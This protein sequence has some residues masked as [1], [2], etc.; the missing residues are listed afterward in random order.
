MVIQLS[1]GHVL[2]WRGYLGHLRVYTVFRAYM[3][4]PLLYGSFAW[5]NGFS[6]WLYVIAW[7]YNSGPLISFFC[8]VIHFFRV[9]ISFCA[10]IQLSRGY[11]V[12]CHGY[13]VHL[14]VYM[15]FR[16]YMTFPWLYGS[17][18]G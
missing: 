11:M 6:S 17:L 9:V 4:F 12:L 2:L 8:M 7:L 1:R 16:G 10:V 15:V 13:L 5:L 18:R 3:T 14:N